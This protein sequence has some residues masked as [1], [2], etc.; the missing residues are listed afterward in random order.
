[1]HLR[2][3]IGQTEQSF[4]AAVLLDGRIIQPTLIRDVRHAQNG[5]KDTHRRAERQIIANRPK[6]AHAAYTQTHR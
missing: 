4:Y 2:G 5:S 6:A 1:V 3:K